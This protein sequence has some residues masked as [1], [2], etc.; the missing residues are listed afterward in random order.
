LTLGSHT[1]EFQFSLPN[2]PLYVTL[3]AIVAGIF[4][5][6]VLFFSTR[7]PPAT[8][9]SVQPAQRDKE[10]RASAGNRKPSPEV[11]SASH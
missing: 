2:G 10:S 7:K 9:S 3:T 5:G 4:L 1:V 8:G 6:G 11:R